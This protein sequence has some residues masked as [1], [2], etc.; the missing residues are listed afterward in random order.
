MLDDV[1]GL[2]RTPLFVL[3]G[4]PITIL[5][6]LTALAIL[7]A[8]RVVGALIVR[9]I[10]RIFTARHVDTSIGFAISKIVRWLVTGIGIVVALSTIGMNLSAVVAVCAVVLVGIGFGLQKLAENFISGLLLL[11]ERPIRIGDFIAV[12]D[13]KGTVEDIGL[14]ATRITTRDGI[15]HL[16]P[17]SELISKLVTNYTTPSTRLRI[18]VTVG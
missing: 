13:H 14:R 6:V 18:W 1:L 16:V 12:E 11:V 8:A 2:L 4:T 7:V 9:S 10:G 3:S 15:T 17:N 5:A